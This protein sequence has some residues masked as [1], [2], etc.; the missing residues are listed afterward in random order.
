MAWLPWL[1]VAQIE[2]MLRLDDVFGSFVIAEIENLPLAERLWRNAQ[3]AR[4]RG[5]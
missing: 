5:F 4:T 3:F 1:M 2:P